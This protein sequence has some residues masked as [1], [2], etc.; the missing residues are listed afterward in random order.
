MGWVVCLQLSLKKN[1]P[2]EVGEV[3][4][5][6]GKRSRPYTVLLAVLRMVLG[7]TEGG[8]VKTFFLFKNS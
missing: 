5:G 8:Q 3:D 2:I 7:A 6:A 4:R 1:E